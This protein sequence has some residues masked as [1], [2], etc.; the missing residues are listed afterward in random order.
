MW[1]AF[2]DEFSE[3][4]GKGNIL[5]RTIPSPQRLFRKIPKLLHDHNPVIESINRTTKF[6]RFESG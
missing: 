4:G 3:N 6:A 5:R 2:V 1:P